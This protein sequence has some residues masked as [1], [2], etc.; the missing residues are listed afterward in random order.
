[1]P[2]RKSGLHDAFRC[3][4]RDL[5]MVAHEWLPKPIQQTP[6]RYSADRFRTIEARR[7]KSPLSE[8]PAIPHCAFFHKNPPRSLQ[9][10]GH[11]YD[12]IRPDLSRSS[13]PAHIAPRPHRNQRSPCVEVRLPSHNGGKSHRAYLSPALP[14]PS[15]SSAPNEAHSTRSIPSTN[16]QPHRPAPLPRK[17]RL[18]QVIYLIFNEG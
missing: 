1:M 17:P 3:R 8:M 12:E 18:A 14:S 16:S 7:R 11:R 4:Q 2:S 9:C 6:A 13:H 15:A 5:A 10:P